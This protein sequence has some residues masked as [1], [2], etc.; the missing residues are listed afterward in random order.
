MW[1]CVCGDVML[2]TSYYDDAM[3]TSLIIMRQVG[4]EGEKHKTL[5]INK[6]APKSQ[7]AHNTHDWWSEQDNSQK[8]SVRKGQKREREREFELLISKNVFVGLYGLNL[9]TNLE[10]GAKSELHGHQKVVVSNE[11]FSALYLVCVCVCERC[12][13]KKTQRE[14]LM[15]SL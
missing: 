11:T 4:C 12:K 8:I 13:V 5:V 10:C 3:M 6:M 15:H 7:G 2:H 14:G 9:L 1:V